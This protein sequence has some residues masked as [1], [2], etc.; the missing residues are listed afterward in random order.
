MMI[1]VDVS[2]DFPLRHGF[3]IR[4]RWCRFKEAWIVELLNPLGYSVDE[5][6]T[7]RKDSVR[8][9]IDRMRLRSE[10]WMPESLDPVSRLTR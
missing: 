2:N 6:R 9:N 3:V 8:R 5:L 4:Q 10:R 7:I 1:D